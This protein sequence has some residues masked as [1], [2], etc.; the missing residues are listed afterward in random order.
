K[1][2][3]GEFASRGRQTRPVRFFLGR[4]VRIYPIY[5]MSLLIGL[6]VQGVVAVWGVVAHGRAFVLLPDLTIGDLVLMLTGFYAFAGQWGG[7]L[8][9]SSW[10]I[11]LI[12]VLY[13]VFPVLS[14]AIRRAP[15]TSLAGLLILSA[16]SRMLTGGTGTLPGDPL[17]WFPVNRM[18]EFG[19]GIFLVRVLGRERLLRWNQLLSRIPSLTYFSA[20]SFPLF[21]VHDPLR[22]LIY[23]GPLEAW[24]SLPAGIPVFIGLSL[25]L[26]ALVLVIN[27]KLSMFLA[28][29]IQFRAYS[30]L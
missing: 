29:K 28:A 6:A 23:L 10:F 14:A 27:E 3:R 20:L 7:P 18:F 2:E 16:A 15:W 9:W 25:V 13:L 17:E 22:R 4:V 8:V 12:M 26:S 5:Y 21:L 19:V 24:Y 30:P 1:T 11:G